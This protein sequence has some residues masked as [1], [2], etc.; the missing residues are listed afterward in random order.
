MHIIR[1][2]AEKQMVNIYTN[3]EGKNS[4]CANYREPGRHRE[5]RERA[6]VGQG[7]K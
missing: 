7:R 1:W 6:A 5:R 4:L 2:A 3:F